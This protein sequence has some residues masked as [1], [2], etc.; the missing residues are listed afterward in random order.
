M[1]IANAHAVSTDCGI[2]KMT[3]HTVLCVETCNGVNN[4]DGM[5]SAPTSTRAFAGFFR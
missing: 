5:I 2:P 4:A 1:T 3:N